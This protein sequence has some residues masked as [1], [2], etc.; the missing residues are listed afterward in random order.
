[1]PTPQQNEAGSREFIDR[2]FNRKDVGFAEG[3]LAEDFVEQSPL[4]PGMGNDKN[5]AL[6]TFRTIHELS[7]DTRCEILDIIATEDRVAIRSRMSGTDDGSGW[8]ALMGAPA[9]GKS[10]SVEGIDVVKVGADG[11]YTE[12][13]GIVDVP[14][15]MTQLGLMPG[16]PPAQ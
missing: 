10:F 16:G 9:T 5:A 7:S 1:M 6:A 13:Y 8:G 11:R 15:M 4:S 2:V 12:H 3:A 14:G